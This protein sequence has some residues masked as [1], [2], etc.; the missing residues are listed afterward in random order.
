MWTDVVSSASRLLISKPDASTVLWLPGQNDAYS[1]TI[2]DRSGLGLNGTIT[3]A[4]WV[5]LQSGLWGIDQDGID[6]TITVT[7]S[8]SSLQISGDMTLE[9]WFYIDDLV[10]DYNT[11][12]TKLTAW[13]QGYWLRVSSLGNLVFAWCDTVLGAVEKF[14]SVN[15]VTQGEWQKIAM[16]KSSTNFLFYR[17]GVQAG[18]TQ[19]TTN[20]VMLTGNT[21]IQIGGNQAS[22]SVEFYDGKI[23]LPIVRNRARSA[24]EIA[25]SFNLERHLFGV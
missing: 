3:G 1:A 22:H 9:G 10:H 8:A 23:G 4:T 25:T 13:S 21:N 19:T 24:S 18:T 2:T 20:G 12:F 6:D 11:L 7:G 16:V 5:R 15:V 17:N 14:C